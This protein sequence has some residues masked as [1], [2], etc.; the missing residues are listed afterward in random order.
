VHNRLRW[1]SVI[2]GGKRSCGLP[3]GG[4]QDVCNGSGG[5]MS[6]EA[7]L[8]LFSCGVGAGV[9]LLWCGCVVAS[10]CSKEEEERSA[11]AAGVID[12]GPWTGDV[13]CGAHGQT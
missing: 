2:G 6:E 1:S 13:E 5:M 8:R 11:A 12:T 10:G 7:N 9:R 4:G 3:I